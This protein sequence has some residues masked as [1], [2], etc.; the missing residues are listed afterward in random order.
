[1]NKLKNS[2][3]VRNRNLGILVLGQIISLFGS[4]I[5]RFALSLYVLDMTGSGSVFASILAFSMVPIVLLAP[6]AGVIA[7]R[8]DRKK[9]MVVLDFMSAAVIAG[10]ALLLFGGYNHVMFVGILM[11]LLSG[12]STI[13]QPAVTSSIPD[14]A[15]EH[16]LM[17]ANGIVQQVS[18]LSNFLG[19]IIAGVLY[20]LVGIQGVVW[21]NGLSF[22]LSAIMELFLKIPKKEAPITG[23]VM[24]VF[25]SDI[26]ESGTYLRHDNP[27]IFRMIFTSGLYNL[28]LVPVFSVG[29]PYIIKIN[30][31]MSNEVYGFAEG[32]IAMGM[33]LGAMIVSMRPKAFHIKK[34]YRVL[35][36]S[37]FSMLMMG[38]CLI[39]PKMGGRVRWFQTAGF[40]L[41]AMSIMLVLGIA[42][43]ISAAFIQR[44][45]PNHMLG[46]ISAYGLAFATLCVPMGQLIFG[47]LL[48]L[49]SAHVAVL[50]MISAVFTFGVTL[51]V[52][53]NVK[54]I[55]DETE[56]VIEKGRKSTK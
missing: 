49:F 31:G 2:I 23:R 5:Q 9:V 1:M 16:E 37:C 8:L 28:F 24:A 12:I 36:W 32:I 33:I 17:A 10:Y 30:L 35:Y 27:V 48:E 43:V 53:W 44:E 3:C 7:D 51:I 15:A 22:F 46:K 38:V 29:A 25:F 55:S 6:I 50:V 54:Q 39:G 13:Y 41:F 45:V 42:N 19:P 56:D 20:G 40:T 18:S 11:F 52:R 34:I 26:K 21:I 4:S 47:A 14:L